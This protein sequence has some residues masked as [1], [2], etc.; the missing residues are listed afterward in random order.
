MSN[1]NGYQRWL[2]F[3]GGIAWVIGF[4]LM[5]GPVTKGGEYCGVPV[6]VASRDVS[7]PTLQST[8]VVSDQDRAQYNADLACQQGAQSRTWGGVLTLMGSAIVVGLGVMVFSGYAT[9]RRERGQRGAAMLSAGWLWAAVILLGLAVLGGFGT[10][11]GEVHYADTHGDTSLSGVLSQ[12]A[13]GLMVG[14]AGGLILA[15][16]LLRALYRVPVTPQS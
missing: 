12:I 1:L 6:V 4:V 14:S 7:P 8:G 13:F 15:I 9:T 2:I 16:Q 3:L 11:F 10:Y 5:L